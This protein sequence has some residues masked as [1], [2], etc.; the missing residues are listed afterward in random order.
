M[1]AA[2]YFK[3]KMSVIPTGASDAEATF[4]VRHAIACD[5]ET[6]GLI[7]RWVE[8]IAYFFT[9]VPVKNQAEQG[10]A[11]KSASLLEFTFPCPRLDN[12]I[13]NVNFTRSVKI[14][15]SDQQVSEHYLCFD[16][17][18]CDKNDHPLPGMW[19]GIDCITLNIQSDVHEVGSV[20]VRSLLDIM[21]RIREKMRL[22]KEHN[23][24][25]GRSCP[26]CSLE[27]H[28]I[29]MRMNRWVLFSGA[30]LVQLFYLGQ[31]CKT[32]DNFCSEYAGKGASQHAGD[33]H[34]Y[35]NTDADADADAFM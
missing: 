15:N 9:A 5:P 4:A 11:I 7:E 8:L 33:A 20:R 32:I 2:V 27:L 17:T 24:P 3:K 12:C 10:C 34:N 25:E 18:L 22:K 16:V 13:V 21:E 26:Q 30:S 14:Y 31:A 23:H 35:V 29:K 28:N 1:C 6:Y 19:F